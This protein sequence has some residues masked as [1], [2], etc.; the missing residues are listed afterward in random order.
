[1]GHGRLDRG[2]G[3]QTLTLPMTLRLKLKVPE[4]G[5]GTW[6]HTPLRY[7]TDLTCPLFFKST[8]QLPS[9]LNPS[10]TRPWELPPQASYPVGPDAATTST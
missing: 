9:F 5:R 6:R 4:L 10:L 7:L 8:T 2:P 3:A 1:M